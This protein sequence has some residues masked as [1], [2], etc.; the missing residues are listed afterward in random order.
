MSSKWVPIWLGSGFKYERVIVQ[1]IKRIVPEDLHQDEMVLA[2]ERFEKEA[3]AHEDSK[4]YI[5]ASECQH[6]SIGLRSK[7]LGDEHPEFLL[8]LERC[9]CCCNFWGMQLL[10]AGQYTQ[11]LEL[12]K[13]AENFTEAEGVPNFKRRV[14]FRAATFS[15]LCCYFR[16]RGKLNAALQF[17]ERA[18]NIGQRY[19]D[20]G[21]LARTRL[22][23]AVLLGGMS[24][25]HEAAG[26]NE[27]AIALL[28]DEEQFLALQKEELRLAAVHVRPSLM[29]GAAS[30]AGDGQPHTSRRES[31]VQERAR[32]FE[33]H[34]DVAH[35][36]A[37]AYYNLSFD[38]SRLGRHEVATSCLAHAAHVAR[39]KLGPEHPLTA[40]IEDVLAS[41]D[42]APKH[43]AA[44]SNSA[45]SAGHEDPP[46]QIHSG[47]L[48]ALVTPPE[49]P[50][51]M[52]HD[53]PRKSEAQQKLKPR[54]PPGHPEGL[55]PPQR[56]MKDKMQLLH[57]SRPRL[58]DAPALQHVG[59]PALQQTMHGAVPLTS[60]RL[61]PLLSGSHEDS[62]SKP[63]TRELKAQPLTEAP[64][65]PQLR[66]AYA[67]HMRLSESQNRKS[68]KEDEICASPQRVQ[69]IAALKKRLTGRAEMG[70]PSN[71]GRNQQRAATVMEKM[72]RGHYARAWSIEELGDDIERLRQAQLKA[73]QDQKTFGPM[74][75]KRQAAFDIVHECR[76]TLVEY[77]AAVR[78]QRTWRGW[79]ARRLIKQEIADVA[80]TS[81]TRIQTL[82]RRHRANAGQR[83][84][85]P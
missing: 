66:A 85:Q 77:E 56:R 13:K 35:T 59:S 32:A 58:K 53:T 2:I 4:Q 20:S 54:A 46:P 73:A 38:E 64:M 3:K 11:A 57:E 50:V 18:L 9:I 52:E 7:L 37:V 45:A 31:S 34:Q 19:K 84:D 51:H 41:V 55:S 48:P 23:Y 14:E 69:A 74:D 27:S 17:A 39:H 33:K 61:K 21:N 62:A 15:N 81:A 78:L 30:N 42:Y 1:H 25:H 16:A 80:S 5:A 10:N 79:A 22:N 67:F 8:A 43:G 6:S 36:L 47:R 83:D 29:A 49:K 72:F 24:R 40:K 65:N 26:H 70:L 76:E 82:F 28:Q 63:S 75:S 44:L 60:L 68:E 71:K 12:L